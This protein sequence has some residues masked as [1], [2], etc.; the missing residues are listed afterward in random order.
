MAFA[1]DP[2]DEQ[3]R[4]RLIRALQLEK[5]MKTMVTKYAPPKHILYV[6]DHEDSRLML[7]HLLKN[8]GYT[9]S[10]ATSI[11]DGLRKAT[12][13]PFDLYIL[14]S[15][16][17]DGSGVELCSQIRAVDAL[18]PII[19]YS[20]A[21]YQADRAAGLAAGAQAYLTKPK[22]IYTIMQTIAELLNEAKPVRV[23]VQRE[24]SSIQKYPAQQYSAIE[25]L[26]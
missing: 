10:T 14:D 15:R 21:A 5:K 1:R 11:A 4:E 23:D 22:G 8:A 18:T 19:F 13:R 3:L 20:S 6:E 9:V 26:A 17:A 12:Q 16:F 24:D 2:F 25:G 7:T